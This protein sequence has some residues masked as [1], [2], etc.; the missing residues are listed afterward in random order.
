MAAVQLFHND[1]RKMQIYDSNNGGG[2]ISTSNSILLQLEEGDVVYIV[3]PTNYGV[4]D[5]LYNR[6]IFSGFLLFPQ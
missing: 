5:Y 6:I 3:L 2:Y 4:Y 1:Q